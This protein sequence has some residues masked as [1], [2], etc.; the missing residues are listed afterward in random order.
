MSRHVTSCRVMSRYVALCH[1]MSRHVTSCRVMSRHV[2]SCHV[3]SRHATYVMYVMSRHGTSCHVMSYHVMSRHVT[4]RHVT[5]CHILPRH[6]TSCHIMLRHITSKVT[7][8]TLHCQLTSSTR[9]QFK[10]S[11]TA[12]VRWLSRRLPIQYRI[13]GIW[14]SFGIFFTHLSTTIPRHITDS[15]S[16]K[17]WRWFE[18]ENRTGRSFCRI[19][20]TRRRWRRSKPPS[21]SSFLGTIHPRYT[22][23]FF[24]NNMS[25]SIWMQITGW[26]SMIPPT[27]RS[28]NEQSLKGSPL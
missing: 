8:P 1:V 5:S 18:F 28:L 26:H 23:K 15:A 7:R 27:H 22:I 9:N 10:L 2:T 19:R 4:S 14:S 16:F 11:M 13:S 24:E 12:R 21:S 20:S 17:C 3:M 25:D 6:V